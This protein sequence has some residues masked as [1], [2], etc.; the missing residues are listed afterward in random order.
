MQTFLQDL[1]YGGRMLLKKPGFTI[2]AA[3]TLALAIGANAAIFSVV[4]AVL[5][6]PLP[7]KEPEQLVWF[8]GVQPMLP[9]ASHSPA[10]FLDYQAQNSSFAEMTAYRNLS[11]TLTEIGQPERIDGRIVSANYFSLLGVEAGI[12]RAFAPQD[13]QAGAARVA[14]LSHGFWQKFFNADPQA[15]GKALTLNGESVTVIGIMPSNFKETDVELWT[16]PKQIVPDLSTTSREDILTVRNNNYLRVIG[17]LKPGVTLAQAQADL[18]AIVARLQQQFPQTNAVRSVRLVS[19][20]ERVVG[21]S[22]QTMLLLFGAVGLVL[23]I[24]S[25]NVANLMIVRAAGR[26]QEIAIRLALGAGRWRIMRQLLTESILLACLGGA[27]GWL[28]AIWGIDLLLALSPDGTPRLSEVRLDYQVFAFT[29]LLSVMTGVVFGLFPALAASKADLNQT[30]KEGG[31]SATAGSGRHRLRSALVIAEVAL[32]LVVL[33]GAGLLIKSFARLQK[34]SPGFDPNGLTTML[35]WLSDA[36]YLEA[37]RRVAFMQQ[38]RTRLGVLPDVQSVAIANDLPIR[39]NDSSNFPIIEGHPTPAPHERILT[40]VHVISPGYFRAMGIPLLKG[41]ELT[42]RDNQNA[43]PV[44]VINETAARRLWP[45]EDPIGKRLMFGSDN[46][47]WIEVIGI[48]GDVKHDGLHEDAGPHVYGSHLQVPW[49]TLKVAVRSRLD[50]AMVATI[51]RRETQGIDPSQPVSDV[52]TM[53]E[54]MADSVAP[55]RFALTLF[56]LFA[57]VAMVLTVIG[58]Y[59]VLAYIVTERTPELGIRMAL[60]AQTHNVLRLV[61]GQGLKLALSGVGIG[62]LGAL[63]L[64]RLMKGLLFEVSATDPLTFALIALL[65]AGVALLACWIPAR[66]AAKIDPIVALRRG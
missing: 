53:D 37:S 35:I 45:G 23:L 15:I 27:C 61:A 1:S 49:P 4:N 21:D 57:G 14:V 64:T 10:D 26:S 62:L 7:F 50:P 6:R 12:G 9:Q 5:L 28:L 17:R 29:L 65:L 38:L 54:I 2:I 34:V 42:E 41:R 47:P 44:M 55:R 8:W 59:G 58:I 32:A 18:N 30:L 36:K 16:N 25:A 33:I 24:A 19:L 43:P 31:R 39:G 60:G 22:R 56:S 48:V 46:S 63:A 66:R 51:V 40:G 52:K 20:H 13:G 3:L 11:F